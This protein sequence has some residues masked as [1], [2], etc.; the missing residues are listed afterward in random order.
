M[1]MTPLSPR[2]GQRLAVSRARCSAQSLTSFCPHRLTPCIFR[3]ELKPRRPL[4][5]SREWHEAEWC[6]GK[7]MTISFSTAAAK[8]RLTER[9]AACK[10][11]VLLSGW[12]VFRMPLSHAQTLRQQCTWSPPLLTV[13]ETHRR[14]RSAQSNKNSSA[15]VC[16]Y[17]QPSAMLFKTWTAA[18]INCE[19][20]WNQT[21]RGLRLNLPLGKATIPSEKCPRT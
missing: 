7:L 2:W 13:A 4:R 1:W 5:L 17:V 14:S 20:M 11:T 8:E 16:V 6:D 15:C 10:A 19:M 9:R 3:C 21:E 12:G 18:P